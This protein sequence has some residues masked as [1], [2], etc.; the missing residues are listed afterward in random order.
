MNE[1]KNPSGEFK[2]AVLHNLLF[3]EELTIKELVKFLNQLGATT[4]KPEYFKDMKGIKVVS[5]K[6]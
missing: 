6:R 5:T 1:E 3:N 2:L 4:S